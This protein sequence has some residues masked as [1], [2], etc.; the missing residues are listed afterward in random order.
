MTV[1][2]DTSTQFLESVIAIVSS[3]AH[4]INFFL[5]KFGLPTCPIC[6]KQKS[7]GQLTCMRAPCL[8]EAGIRVR[9]N[10]ALTDTF[11]DIEAAMPTDEDLERPP[12]NFA[13]VAPSTPGSPKS[14][15][16]AQTPDGVRTPS[17]PS[18][19]NPVRVDGEYS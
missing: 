6:L 12:G 1:C 7:I 2:Q 17:W 8:K 9:A 15:S 10:E 5:I 4:P 16:D 11:D 19:P 13:T 14:S 3:I 18:T